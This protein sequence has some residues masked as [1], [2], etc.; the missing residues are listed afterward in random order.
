[1]KPPRVFISYSHDS[2]EHKEWVLKFAT[3]LRQRGVDAVLDQWDL[4]PGFDLPHF[5]ETELASCDYAVMVC[6]ERYVAKANGGEGGVGYEKMIMTS[7]LLSKISSSN[8]IPIL[9]NNLTGHVPTFMQSKLYVDFRNDTDV[10]YSLDE[11][12]RT[13]LNAPLYEK[14]EIG[15]SPFKPLNKAKPDRVSDG[16]KEAMR[17]VADAYNS[18]ANETLVIAD[19]RVNTRMH[20]LTLERYLISAL[21]DQLVTKDGIDRYKITEKGIEYLV[22]HDLIKA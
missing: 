12:L 9:R 8:I 10:E 7:S 5:M 3:T 2:A 6:S 15:N 4:K 18:T 21:R 1:M 20:R 17:A 22:A 14:P 11:L 19:I 13:L 16:T